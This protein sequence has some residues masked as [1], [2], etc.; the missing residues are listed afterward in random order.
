[1]ARGKS[2]SSSPLRYLEYKKIPN[3]S[4][5]EY[6]FLWGLRACHE[7]SKMR[8]LRFIA[9]VMEVLCW[10]PGPGAVT[11]QP[12]SVLQS[13]ASYAVCLSS[14]DTETQKSS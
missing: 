8:V 10:G 3:S 4:P 7:T 13:R 5:S 2:L 9:Q 1:M 6:E 11:S 12:L 14:E